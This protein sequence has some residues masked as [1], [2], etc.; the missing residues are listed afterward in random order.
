MWHCIGVWFSNHEWL[1]IWLE[2]VALVAI[3]FLDWREYKRQGRERTE[4]HEESAAQLA[5]MQSQADAARDNANT[6]KEG[7]EAAK[8]NAEAARLNAEAGKAMVELLISK[9]RARIQIIAGNVPVVGDTEIG[10]RCYLNNVGPTMA[11]IEGGGVVLLDAG[12]D[13]EVDYARCVNIPFVGNVPANSRTPTEFVIT[14]QPKTIITNAQVLEIREGKSFIHCYGYVGYRDVFEHLHRVQLHL[15]WTM[16]W[17]GMI[18]GQIMEWW[19]TV[20]KPEENSDI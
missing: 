12:R 10:I 20:G 17:G 8:A 13:I 14:L 19:E 4:Q 5:I 9:D 1:A 2:G 3:F 6:A 18:E 15:R 7:A 11:F 16:R